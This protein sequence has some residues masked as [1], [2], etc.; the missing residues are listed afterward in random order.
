VSGVNRQVFP[1][2]DGDGKHIIKAAYFID[3]NHG[4]AAAALSGAINRAFEITDTQ[5]KGHL[6]RET[7]FA[8]IYAAA[9]FVFLAA[10]AAAGSIAFRFLLILHGCSFLAWRILPRSSILILF[11]I[12][13]PFLALIP[14]R[15]LF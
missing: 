4:S 11:Y 13:P 3:C 1:E 2:A 10:P 12:V 14:E 8:M 9:L 5:F 6:F 7:V 15:M